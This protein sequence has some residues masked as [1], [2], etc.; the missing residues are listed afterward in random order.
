MAGTSAAYILLTITLYR[1]AGLGDS[2][3]IYANVI[4]LLA[5][6]VYCTHFI[7]S[8][9]RRRKGGKEVKLPTSAD[10]I[11]PSTVLF[12]SVLTCLM[13]RYSAHVLEVKSLCKTSGRAILRTDAFRLHMGV[14]LLAGMA[15]SAAW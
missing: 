12:V 10:I 8:L 11:P 14:G 15:M 2:A 13:T 1:T 4:N 6:I 9:V 3:V 5:R 7:A